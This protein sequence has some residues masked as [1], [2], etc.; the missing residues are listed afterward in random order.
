MFLDICAQYRGIVR[1][2][3]LVIDPMGLMVGCGDWTS[4]AEMFCLKVKFVESYVALLSS[5]SCNA[6]AI[7]NRKS[8]NNRC[9]LYLGQFC[10][11]GFSAIVGITT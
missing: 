9:F 6:L 7:V 4:Q 2:Q 8:T 11:I 10:E 1:I 3:R 5:Q